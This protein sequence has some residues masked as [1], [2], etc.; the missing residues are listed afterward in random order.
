MK[1]DLLD[2]LKIFLYENHP[3]NTAK[4][5]HQSV[6]SLFKNLSFNDVSE[7]PREYIEN[8]LKAQ[9]TKNDLSAAKM[10]L[11][12]FAQLNPG[13]ELPSGEF[14]SRLSGYKKNYKK[15]KFD[16]I[17]LDTIK[18]KIN[19]I[20]DKRIK[21]ACRLMIACG[22]RIS[23][24]AALCAEHIHIDGEKITLQIH[25]KGEKDRALTVKIDPFTKEHLQKIIDMTPLGQP[26]FP[27][28]RTIQEEA[29]K[30][31]FECH[32]LRRAF[33]KKYLQE[34]RQELPTYEANAKLMQAMGHT[35]WETTQKYLRRQIIL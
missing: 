35:K 5:Y 12:A 9:K 2:D 18:R 31:G 34:C 20:S 16:P 6:K 8:Q 11:L 29:N 1:F 15:R 28:A 27:S 23:E 21:I 26:L 14:F 4:K 7:I 32:D 17:K 13:L 3:P 24:T 33:A 22:A 19:R 30:K 10:G 25:G